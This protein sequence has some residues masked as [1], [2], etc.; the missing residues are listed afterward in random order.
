MGNVFPGSAWNRADDR[1]G[2]AR[3]GVTRLIR[4]SSLDLCIFQ[5]ESENDT[6]FDQSMAT[7]EN[8]NSLELEI[9]FARSSVGCRKLPAGGPPEIYQHRPSYDAG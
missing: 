5:E 8:A 3:D 6:D 4:F 9:P 7:H 2:A 1:R